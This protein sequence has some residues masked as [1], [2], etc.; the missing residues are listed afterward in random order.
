MSTK[1]EKKT[2]STR[3]RRSDF[4]V[5]NSDE[6]ELSEDIGSKRRGTFHLILYSLLQLNPLQ[7]FDY[8]S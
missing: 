8:S 5:D 2:I 4:L 7:G 3:K 6:G 1:K